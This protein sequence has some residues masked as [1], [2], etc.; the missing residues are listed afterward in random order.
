MAFRIIQ[1]SASSCIDSSLR[2]SDT[3]P[4]IRMTV[5]GPFLKPATNV[6]RP[7]S[8][9]WIFPSETTQTIWQ[10]NQEL[11]FVL[12][13]WEEVFFESGAS[14]RLSTSCCFVTLFPFL[15]ALTMW[16]VSCLGSSGDHS[17]NRL[18]LPNLEQCSGFG[19][20]AF[21]DLAQNFHLNISGRGRDE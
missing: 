4:T 1:V 14:Y 21:L 13:S 19:F 3:V 8:H 10:K 2:I 16:N 6:E 7:W 11:G 12:I 9:E 20:S 5:L 17:R 18:S 15:C